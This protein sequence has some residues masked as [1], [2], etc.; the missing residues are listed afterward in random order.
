MEEAIGA[1]KSAKQLYLFLGFKQAEIDSNGQLKSKRGRLKGEGGAS[2]EQ[3]AVHRQ[4]LAEMEIAERK[5]FLLNLGDACDQAANKK[6]IG[7]PECAA[8]FDEIF[9]KV[10]HLFRFMQ[11]V[12]EARRA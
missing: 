3:R 8:E 7:D 9:P 10:E 5:A 6:G 11:G 12:K 1:S 2:R 4:K